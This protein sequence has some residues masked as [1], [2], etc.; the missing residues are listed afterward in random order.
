MRSSRLARVQRHLVAVSAE[1]G[2][3]LVRPELALGFSVVEMGAEFLASSSL[4]SPVQ[5]LP[6]ERFVL[7]ELLQRPRM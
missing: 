6:V 5:P 2:S 1:V 4:G 7:V 3:A